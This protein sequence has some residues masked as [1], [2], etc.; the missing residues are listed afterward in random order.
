VPLDKIDDLLKWFYSLDQLDQKTNHRT[1][2]TASI[3]LAPSPTANPHPETADAT[4]S[5]FTTTAHD[6]VPSN[7]FRNSN[8]VLPEG[9]VGYGQATEESVALELT[10][11][12][13]V[14]ISSAQ[15]STA[16]SLPSTY[17]A[18][19]LV[20]SAHVRPGEHGQNAS[21][22]DTLFESRRVEDTIRE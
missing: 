5:L 15:M 13:P 21:V 8:A 4:A 20:E 2:G 10:V 11:L 1:R 18:V 7:V 3:Q 14:V 16:G 17:D 9:L 12:G 22:L 19:L 6:E